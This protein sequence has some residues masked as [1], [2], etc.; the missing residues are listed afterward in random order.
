MKND[1]I[2]LDDF[3]SELEKTKN[4]LKEGKENEQD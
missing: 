3:F 1:E 2:I 4:K